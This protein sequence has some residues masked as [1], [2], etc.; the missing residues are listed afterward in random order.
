MEDLTEGELESLVTSNNSDDARFVL[1]RLLLEGS[2]DKIKKNEKK[3]INWIKEAIKN[4]HLE[5]L[6]YKTYFD[7]RFDKQPNM[8]KILK[9]LETVV[10]K[11][12][13]S[14]SCNTLA[15]FYQ[16]QDKKEGSQQEAAKYYSMS[17]EQGCQIGIH[18][19]GVFYQQAFGVSKNIDKAIDFLTRSAKLGNG[20]SN[21]QLFIIYSVEESH[22][23]V[24]KAYAYLEKA[25]Q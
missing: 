9:N 4:N 3:G 1:G 18:W 14:R 6:E 10:E 24:K 8:K 13:S 7:I 15:E 22:K 23:D 12:K 20:Q 2:S 17:A 19:M 25:I 16:V 11:S 5:A 21:Y